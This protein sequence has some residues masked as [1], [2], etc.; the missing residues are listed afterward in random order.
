MTLLYLA[1]NKERKRS[2]TLMVQRWEMDPLRLNVHIASSEATR[3]WE[4]VPLQSQIKQISVHLRKKDLSLT[5]V[6]TCV[7]VC[8]WVTETFLSGQKRLSD[9]T[10]QEL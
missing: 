6:Y 7:S 5:H 2:A 3:Y 4:C 8:V 1:E 10:E 9:P